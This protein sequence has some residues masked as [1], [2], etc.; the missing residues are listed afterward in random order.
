MIKISAVSYL[1]TLPFAYGIEQSDY[2]KKNSLINRDIPSECARKLKEGEVD[3][4][5]VPVAI[6]PQIKNPHVISNFCIGA[7]GKVHSVNLYSH[8]PIDQITEIVLDYQSKTSVNLCKVLCKHYWD[9]SP[10]FI[11]GAA[12]YEQEVQPNQAA[13]II[14]DRTFNIGEEFPYVYDLSE[15]WHHM[16]GLPFV[17]AAWVAN[18][19]LPDEYISAFN[20]A[21][22]FGL[23]HVKEAIAFGKISIISPDEQYQ[24]LTKSISYS[25]DEQKRKGLAHFLS[26]LESVA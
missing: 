13:V 5:L 14:G 21:A 18:R 6:I 1:N 3:L 12:G 24:Y 16:T 7:I 25:L 10:S 11:Q 2:I 19:P 17:F 15:E 26:L 9:I 20:K 22:E 23:E 8:T 4:G